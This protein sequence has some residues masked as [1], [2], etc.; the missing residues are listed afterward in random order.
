[1]TPAVVH[2]SS[3]ACEHML[4]AQTN[5][6]QGLTELKEAGAW[7]IGLDGGSESR[8]IAEVNLKGPLVLVVGSEG[9]GMRPLVRRSCDAL[10]RLPM[11]GKVESLN[12]AVAGSVALYLALSN[13]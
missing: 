10:A 2:A 4:V 6:A 5:M 8:P 9:E 11:R 7:V 3:G 1:V 13:R 12:A